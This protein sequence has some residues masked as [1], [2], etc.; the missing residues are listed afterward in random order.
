[1]TM[2]R[3][4]SGTL[5]GGLVLVGALLATRA[6]FSGKA[7]DT[8]GNAPMNTGPSPM[9][10]MPGCDNAPS[11][12]LAVRMVGQ[13]IEGK[14]WTA[15]DHDKIAPLFYGLH[16]DQKIEILKKVGAAVDSHRL[17]LEKG[18]RLF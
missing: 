4:R 13:V 18:A 3:S 15:K 11:F 5:I 10:T 2:K 9:P 1:M 8:L 17:V 6:A 7:S 12:E 16:T 14:R